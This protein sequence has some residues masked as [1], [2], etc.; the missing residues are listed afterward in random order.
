M[1]KS[2]SRSHHPLLTLTVLL[3]AA[4]SQAASLPKEIL[5]WPDGAP[6]SEGKTGAERVRVANTNDH[7]ISNIHRPSI[8]P[9]LPSKR[10]ATGC[11]VIVAP[12]GGHRE[13]WI[14]HEGYNVARWLSEHGIA[15]FVLKYRLARETNSTYTIDDHALADMQRALRVVRSRAGE[16]N[17][18]PNRLGVMGFS[19]GGE[20]AFLSAQ[21]FDAGA[22]DAAEPL[23]RQSSRPDFQALIYPGRSQRIEPSSN[24]PPVFLVC[25]YNDRPD[26]SEGLANVYLK[27]KQLKVPAELHIYAGTGHGFGLRPNNTHPVGKWVERFDEWLADNGFL[28]KR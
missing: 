1:R 23:A 21:R 28:K 11:A 3:I 6:G 7:V 17:L 13:L 4:V 12:G 26:I 18:D 9:F 10:K 14:D 24:S 15:A 16:W 25:G 22:P 27:F 2:S 8:T 5:L 20:V 19:A